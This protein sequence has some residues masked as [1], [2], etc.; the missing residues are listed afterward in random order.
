MSHV[1]LVLSSL[2]ALL[3]SAWPCS[4]GSAQELDPEQPT[5]DAAYVDTRW[6]MSLPD[7]DPMDACVG[8]FW[9]FHFFRNGYFVYS[10][11]VRGVWRVDQLGNIRLKTRDGVA[12][13]LLVSGTTF[14]PNATVT[15]VKRSNVFQRCEQVTAPS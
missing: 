9:T 13:T 2:A 11:K 8:G 6:A 5:G 7:R 12:L 4:Q 10:N 3:W 1:R 14:R 15:F